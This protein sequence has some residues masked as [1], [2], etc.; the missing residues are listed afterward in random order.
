MCTHARS[1]TRARAR[2]R[3]HGVVHPFAHPRGCSAWLGY[4]RPAEV[5]RGSETKRARNR[6]RR[7]IHGAQSTSEK[8]DAKQVTLASFQDSAWLGYLHL[9]KFTGGQCLAHFYGSIVGVLTLCCIVSCFAPRFLFSLSVL[10]FFFFFCS[11]NFPAP[12]K[13]CKG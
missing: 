12:L 13:V 3:K 11:T 1:S 6:K 4:A 8:R 2:V 10:S 5:G 9:P 7:K